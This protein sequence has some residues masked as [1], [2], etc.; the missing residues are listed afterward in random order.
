MPY[1][2]IAPVL[3]GSAFNP[4]DLLAVQENVDRSD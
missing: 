2:H 3:L 1:D 4:I